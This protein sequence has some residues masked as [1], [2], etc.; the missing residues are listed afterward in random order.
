MKEKQ[1]EIRVIF[2][3]NIKKRRENLGLTQENLAEMADLSVQTINTIE[4]CRMWISDKSITRLAKAL[5]VEIF[6]LFMPNQINLKEM[7]P[8]QIS[9]L[10]T[11]WQ[12]TKLVLEKMNS[13]I[14]I[15]FKDVLK[16][17]RQSKKNN[18][19]SDNKNK[20]NKANRI[21]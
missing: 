18:I 19:I 21:K 5:N 8:E 14:D 3:Q 11:F 9:V 20:Y 16:Q 13:Q 7:E 10:L 15:E 4:S 17:S 12:K 1:E 6:Q 2:A